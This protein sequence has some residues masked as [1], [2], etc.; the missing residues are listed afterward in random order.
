MPPKKKCKK[1]QLLNPTSNRCA[2][3][4]TYL[5]KTKKCTKKNRTAII[6]PKTGRCVLVGG[7]AHKKLM[8]EAGLAKKGGRKKAVA[9]KPA[10][11]K[12]AAKKPAAKPRKAKAKPAARKPAAKPRKVKA[13]PAA[14]PRKAKA[15][16]KPKKGKNMMISLD[17]VVNKKFIFSIRC[18]EDQGYTMGEKISAGAWGA[19]FV[20][21]TDASGCDRVTKLVPLSKTKAEM[22]KYMNKGEFEKEAAISTM[23]SKLGTGPLVHETFVCD[24][25]P[26]PVG[27][28]VLDRWDGSLTDA[29]AV[30]IHEQ[31]AKNQPD[32][33]P[34]SHFLAQKLTDQVELLHHNGFLH[35]D[36]LP[37][38]ILVKRKGGEITDVTLTDWGA[39]KMPG[40]EAAESFL[41][42]LI[43]YFQHHGLML[44]VDRDAVVADPR[45]F[46]YVMI[47]WLQGGW[48][49]YP[50]SKEMD[51]YR[52]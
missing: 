48:G 15:A 6:N 8:V 1:P 35:F 33:Y 11:R 46:D 21:C 40:E 41:T 38:N 43:D 18:L 4:A 12:P 42:A 9:K 50:G 30:R 25:G 29:E 2:K 14:K 51:S 37:K 17:N 52:N 49:S 32:M 34:M 27:I 13:K 45:V 26:R 16:A 5:K 39:A 31:N 22:E 44:G 3:L 28:I 47:S 19:A 20:A 36:I 7:D 24:V 10:A 23:M